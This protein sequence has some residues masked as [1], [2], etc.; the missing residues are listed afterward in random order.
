VIIIFRAVKV[1]SRHL[2][3]LLPIL[4]VIFAWW[5]GYFNGGVTPAL[6]IFPLSGKIIGIDP[7]HGGYDPGSKRDN[8]LEKDVVLG[9]GL[10]LREY[11]QQGGAWVVMTRE[12]DVDLLATSAGPKKR[13][14]M[15]NR[16]QIIEDS[17]VELLVSIHANSISSSFWRGAQVFYQEG[18]DNGKL[19]A[20]AIQDELIRVLQNTER[21]VK[22]GDYYI[23]RET[24]MTGVVVEAGFLSN[25]EEA[26][27][28][29]TA[30][31]QKKVAWAI[32][33]G[34]IK[35]LS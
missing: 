31:Y 15:E 24:S 3:F 25:P 2:F 8:I 13:L 33:L 6:A 29:S 14:D 18:N 21:Q 22:S 35:Y 32:Y 4:F 23:I 19:L 20:S 26:R 10:Y 16:R 1:S 34:I 9:I 27:L 30:E 12:E 7:G 11:L 5:G 17:G 28:L